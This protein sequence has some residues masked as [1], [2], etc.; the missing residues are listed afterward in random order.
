M[1]T[2]KSL[3]RRANFDINQTI[4]W[5]MLTDDQCEEIFV[6]A[7]ELL[8]RTGSHIDNKEA[9]ELFAANGCW[10]DGNIVRIP[11]AK[12]E[13]AVRSAPSRITLC[14][15]SGKRAVLMETEN[16]HFG[17]YY[18]SE[19]IVDRASGKQ[20][21]ITVADAV[22][23]A[24]LS[25]SLNNV[26]FV[27]APGKPEGFRK[28]TAGLYALEALLLNS[29]K[30]IIQPV[31]NGKE[32]EMV[33]EM[34]AAAVGGFDAL[35]QNPYVVFSINCNEPRFHSEDSLAAVMY[36]AKKGIPFIYQNKLISGVT[37]PKATAGTLVVALAN[38]LVAL[39]LAQF[40]SEGAQMIAGGNFTIFD[41]NN[42]VA[43]FGAPEA[44]LIGAGFS[45]LMRYLRIPSA[46]VSG[47]SD[48]NVSD[49]QLGAEFTY[50]ILTSVLAGTNLI[51]GGGAMESGKVASS[52]ALAMTDEVM[53]AIHR[54][55]R[56]F[57]IDEDR[58]ARGVIDEVGPGG[59]YLGEDHTTFF[60]KSE[61]FWPNLTNR[62]R[63]DDWIA[64]GSKPMGQRALEY[65]ED[66]LSQPAVELVNSK[67]AAEI[68][69]ILAKAEATL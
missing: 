63:I 45:N 56:T 17:P 16:S 38:N 25:E 10:V 31:S 50:G 36:A 2:T 28:E 59:N 51:G 53:G 68:K 11:S 43:P 26:S 1:Y 7:A 55:M 64:D 21:K 23:T 15:K 46:G 22:D 60:F 49:A 61:Q 54:I 27:S 57:D 13:S 40:V 9:R 18:G 62:K 32:A 29:S 44:G 48:S 66:L 19:M 34:A 30:P 67:V 39:T 12:L 8:E 47:I 41:D 69:S 35:R 37:A 58:M 20:R 4:C 24:R 52:A 42:G 33:A 5:K 3:Y 14:N 6:T 65:V